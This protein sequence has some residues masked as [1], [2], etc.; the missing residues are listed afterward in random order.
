M[1]LLATDLDG[2][3]LGGSIGDRDRLY[4][5][6]RARGDQLILVFVTGRAVEN[7]TS[8]L[9]DAAIPKPR[10]IIADVGATVTYGDGQRRV[11]PLD[12]ALARRWIG[13]EAVLAALDGLPLERQQ[14]AQERR[15]SFYTDDEGVVAAAKRAVEPLGC[16]V[17]YSASRYLDI[18]PA[19]VNKGSTL[20]ALV[21]HL[22]IDPL[23]VFIA[24]DSLNDLP[25]FLDTPF[26]GVV[27]GGS[28][29]DLYPHTRPLKRVY[30]AAGHGA[31]GITEA[32]AAHQVLQ[33]EVPEADQRGTAELVV[34]Y[35][36]Q[37]FDESVVNGT[38]VRQT[39]HSP[40]GIIPTLL[41]LFRERRGVWVAWTYSQ[42]GHSERCIKLDDPAFSGLTISRVSLS[43]EDVGLFYKRF[44]KEALWPILHGCVDRAQFEHGHWQHF[45]AI[46][47]RFASQIAG[48]ASAGALVWVHDYNLWLVPEYL[49]R[50]RPDLRIAFFLHTPFPAADVF[51]VIPWSAEITGS[52]LKCDYIGFHIPRY[53]EN[54]VD[55]ARSYHAIT[56]QELLDS[57]DRFMRIGAALSCA[58]NTGS[59]LHNQHVVHL[60][61]HPVGLD[62]ARVQSAL[63]SAPFADT[64]ASLMRSLLGRR[65]IVSAERLDYTKGT[66][67]RLQAF[68]HF[69]ARHPLW[70]E[71]LTLV[72]ICTPAH[73]G[74]HIYEDIRIQI[75]QTVGR[76]NGRFATVAWTPV[77]FMFRALSFDEL[78]AYLAVADIAWITPLRDGLNLVAKEYVAIHD[79]LDRPG[80]LVLSEFAGCS[81]ELRGALLA[82]P[83]DIVAMADTLEQGLVMDA[84]E[85]AERMRTLAGVVRRYDVEQWS[86]DFVD[87]ALRVTHV[88]RARPSGPAA[89]RGA[90]SAG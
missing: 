5:W 49:R 31:A 28:E 41:G 16:E 83:Y 56:V 74:M 43:E 75:E 2:T 64:S 12:A 15:C 73:D 69:L 45:V 48:E 39:I 85:R 89:A 8:L 32:L 24:G 34:V 50:W 84:A 61:I 19:G 9:A 46:N 52:L 71:K 3:F 79:R 60:G 68:E 37:P 59:V 44:S 33:P 11:E 55:A 20:R 10:Y 14:Q 40:N 17:L 86:R 51:N 22:N 65:L 70:R 67:Q 72:S 78:A 58:R 29:P 82:N 66:P 25:M 77:V 54:F 36:R 6:A 88:R 26:R 90:V 13:A 63:Q 23:S 80:V 38:V 7:V 27:V 81:V 4:Q 47:Q 62:P 87:S 35:H 30:H 1:L 53:A 42:P 57:N 76:I 18:L 21:A